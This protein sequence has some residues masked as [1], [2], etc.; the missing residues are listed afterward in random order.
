M[1]IDHRTEIEKLTF[2]ALALRPS[3]W[4]RA[5]ARNVSFSHSDIVWRYSGLKLYLD[6]NFLICVYFKPE[7]V[8]YVLSSSW[9][10][11]ELLSHPH[12]IRQESVKRMLLSMHLAL[13]CDFTTS[14]RNLEKAWSS[15]CFPS[16]PPPR[17]KKKKSAFCCCLR[18]CLKQQDTLSSVRTSPSDTYAQIH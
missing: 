17:G 5:N 9:L 1:Q 16:P 14:L 15:R 8:N 2:R 10:L 18:F 4:Q 3:P 13:R 12:N 7:F 6:R 11:H